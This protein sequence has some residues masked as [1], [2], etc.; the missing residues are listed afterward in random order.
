MSDNA[1][2]ALAI[3]ILATVSQKSGVDARLVAPPELQEAVWRH[4]SDA[5]DI[6]RNTCQISCQVDRIYETHDG[7][8]AKPNTS[9]VPA[10][11]LKMTNRIIRFQRKMVWDPLFRNGGLFL[12]DHQMVH[13]K[14]V[15][16]GGLVEH[17]PLLPL[18]LSECE[19]NRKVASSFS[20]AKAAEAVIGG[21]DVPLFKPAPTMVEPIVSDISPGLEIHGRDYKFDLNEDS[22]DDDSED[23]EDDDSEEEELKTD[24]LID[25]EDAE[26][27]RDEDEILGAG[28]GMDIASMINS[29]PV[30]SLEPVNIDKLPQTPPT[31]VKP[32]RGRKKKDV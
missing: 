29:K 11:K 23:E 27:G 5:E 7:P 14:D 20:L 12:A 6:L 17:L 1:I 16:I 25:S 24:S 18:L 2:Q 10:H 26:P 19:S 4:Y 8:K 21:I 22:E 31:V 3:K 13:W 9:V 28:S 30:A 32:R 15:P